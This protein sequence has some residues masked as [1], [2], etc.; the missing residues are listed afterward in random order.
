MLLI[1]VVIGK[2]F[3]YIYVKREE[4]YSTAFT[5]GEGAERVDIFSTLD[6]CS[7]WVPHFNYSIAAPED[8]SCG[9]MRG[10][11]RTLVFNN[12][13]RHQHGDSSE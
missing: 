3:L 11:E 7:S 4:S 2:V 10:G 1:L 5:N 8:H 9:V 12:D 13:S 6:E